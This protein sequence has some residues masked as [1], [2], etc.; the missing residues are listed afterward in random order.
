MLLLAAIDTRRVGII[1]TVIWKN[2]GGKNKF[3]GVFLA[4][5]ITSQL[6]KDSKNINS[7]VLSKGQRLHRS[8][9][10]L[11]TCNNNILFGFLYLGKAILGVSYLL[12][13]DMELTRS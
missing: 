7:R 12:S 1:L 13:I 9:T 2:I 11:R 5:T 4:A 6:A 8:R 3:T 10:G